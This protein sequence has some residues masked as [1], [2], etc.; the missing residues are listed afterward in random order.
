M[1]ENLSNHYPRHHPVIY[2]NTFE[3]HKSFQISSIK[4]IKTKCRH[5]ECKLFPHGFIT[6]TLI[7]VVKARIKQ[8]FG[9]IKRVDKGE[10]TTVKDLEG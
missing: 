1:L 3:E 2:V 8:K 4:L 7:E 9:F 6:L 10:I 5:T